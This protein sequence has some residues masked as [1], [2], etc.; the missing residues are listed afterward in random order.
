ARIASL[1]LGLSYETPGVTINCAC[2]SSSQAV[3]VGANAIALG[4]AEVVL[5]GGVESM[6]NGPYIME[7]A[8]WGQRLRHAQ[9]TDLIWKS[10]QEYPVGGGMGIVAERLAEKYGLSRKDQDALALS[11]HQRA[12]RAIKEGRFKRE[13]VPVVLPSRK[14]TVEITTDE[15]PRESTS[16][17]SL[18]QLKP[19]FK[20]GG[21]VTAGN[22]SSLND[23]AAALILM[24]AEKARDL[25]IAPMDTIRA[26]C[27]LAVDP[28]ILGIAPVPAIQKVLKETGLALSDIQLFEINEAFAAYYLSCEKELGLNREITNVNG[29]GISLGHP[30]G[31]TGS[32]IL[33]TLLYE[34]E[35]Q[36]LKFGI[37]SL[38]A[39]GGVGT[40]ILV[41]R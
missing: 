6:S 1:L 8:R 11:S 17:E 37:A 34:M 22:A 21:T 29:S 28:H 27:S 35:R 39:G 24:S 32:R 10:M 25:G 40:A 31:C 23:G 38:C 3:I 19:A 5:A 12:V 4:Q 16:L 14:K 2:A 20:E 36:D 9:A 26:T 41:E 18:A 13:I 15:H 7:S 30:V 33:V